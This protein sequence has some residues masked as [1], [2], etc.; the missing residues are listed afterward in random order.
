VAISLPY[1]C[2]TSVVW[3]VCLTLGQVF[4]VNLNLWSY[5]TDRWLEPILRLIIS[6]KV[7]SMWD[8]TFSRRWR[9]WCWSSGL[10]CRVNLL[11]DTNVSDKRT[12]SFFRVVLKLEALCLSETL[13]STYKST[14]HHNSDRHLHRRENLKLKYS[15]CPRVRY[16]KL[17]YKPTMTSLSDFKRNY[18]ILQCFGNL[19]FKVEKLQMFL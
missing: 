16:S 5:R 18:S 4:L 9:C 13:I 6:N 11:V 14:R 7:F 2:G 17:Y 3:L 10:W 15:W 12:A 19:H 8:L 1:H